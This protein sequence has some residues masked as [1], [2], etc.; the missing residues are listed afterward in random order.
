MCV[1]WSSSSGFKPAGPYCHCCVSALVFVRR[2]VISNKNNISFM[3]FA[4][5]CNGRQNDSFLPPTRL[6]LRPAAGCL[7]A[8]RLLRLVRLHFAHRA[9]IRRLTGAEQRCFSLSEYFHFNPLPNRAL[10]E[11]LCRCIWRFVQTADSRSTVVFARVH[12]RFDQQADSFVK[13][14]STL[15]AGKALIRFC[16]VS[17]RQ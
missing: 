6:Q 2:I 15:I 13:Q 1:H 5:S 9:S 10:K 4:C 7:H 14:Q 3:S 11:H 17:G 16:P 8:P 12:S